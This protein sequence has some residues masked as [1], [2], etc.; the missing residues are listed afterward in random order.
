MPRLAQGETV[1]TMTVSS[2]AASATLGQMLLDAAQRHRGVAL[3]Y[4][5]D[6]QTI[7]I[8]Y[9]Q[10]AA[11]VTEIA[12]GLIAAGIEHGDRVAILGATSAN[13]TMADHGALCAGAVVA[14]IYDT[15]APE[16]CAY[17]LAHSG[18]RLVFC[19]DAAQAAK[20]AEIREQCP[21]LEQVVLFDGAADGAIICQRATSAASSASMGSSPRSL[22]SR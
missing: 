16:E 10:L 7:S 20:I 19:Q 21:R 12:R 18:A 5:R 14:P 2:P 4:R 6:D 15:N 3:D 17:V 8:S 22:R 13:W 11:I 1:A 9:P